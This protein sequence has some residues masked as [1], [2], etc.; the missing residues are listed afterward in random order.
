MPT[1]HTAT[2]KSTPNKPMKLPLGNSVHLLGVAL[3]CVQKLLEMTSAK[4]WSLVP[5]HWTWYKPT[6]SLLTECGQC[7]Q[8]W[9]GKSLLRFHRSSLFWG[10]PTAVSDLWSGSHTRRLRLPTSTPVSKPSWQLVRHWDFGNSTPRKTWNR[11]TH[12]SQRDPNN[13][14]LVF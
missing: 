11:I 5:S 8:R 10:M 9:G 12:F 3:K 1:T 2:S 13:M 7:L 4:R 14:Y 6:G